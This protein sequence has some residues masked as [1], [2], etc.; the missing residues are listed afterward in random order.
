MGLK[1]EVVRGDGF[2]LFHAMA[3]A[4]GRKGEGLVVKEE[5]LD[6]MRTHPEKYQGLVKSPWE[7]HLESIDAIGWGTESEIEA[8]QNLYGRRLEIWY[9]GLDGNPVQDLQYNSDTIG[10]IKLAYYPN[11]HYNVLLGEKNSEMPSAKEGPKSN[12]GEI[13][14]SS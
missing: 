6:E 9:P 13:S 10:T 14:P 3:V 8:I 11:K 1:Y 7:K 2:C 12:G 5:V 4:L